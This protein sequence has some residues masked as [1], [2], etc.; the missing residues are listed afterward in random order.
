MEVLDSI[1]RMYDDIPDVPE[2][3][4]QGADT[5]EESAP[6]RFKPAILILVVGGIGL[7]ALILGLSL[8]FRS[9]G[10]QTT[11]TEQEGT[12]SVGTTNPEDASST[13]ILGHF[14]YP[15]APANELVA[16]SEDGQI[17]LRT[18]AANAYK[19]MLAAAVAD[20]VSLVALS[21]FRS[22]ADQEYLF[23]E[24]KE[25]RA[26][27]AAK[28]A[29]VSA[30]PGHSEHHTG[31]AIDLGDPNQSDTHLSESFEQTP[32]FQWLEANAARFSFELSFP[33]GNAQGISYEPWHWRFVG[34]QQS[35]KTF[36]SARKGPENRSSENNSGVRSRQ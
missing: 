31:Y 21:G 13:S 12:S 23:F 35:L 28:R 15:E 16:I 7:L 22:I 29:E 1:T 36:Y 8:R 25:E 26:Q 34:D 24:V 17:R 14:P 6:P 11:Q 27:V 4:R 19:R 9:G 3:V 33:R 10:F 5:A 20:G 30:P 32:A 18:S 2:A